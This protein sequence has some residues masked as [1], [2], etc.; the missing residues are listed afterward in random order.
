[1]Q[2]KAK[3]VGVCGSGCSSNDSGIAYGELA[4]LEGGNDE[5]G[6]GVEV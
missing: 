1:M 3:V 4:E 5:P 2:I 6:G